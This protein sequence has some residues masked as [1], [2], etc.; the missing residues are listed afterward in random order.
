M[1]ASQMETLSPSVPLLPLARLLTE[2]LVVV[3][4]GARWGF[5]Q[6]WAGLGDRCVSV[7]FEPDRVECERLVTLH[8]GR[9]NLRFVPLALGARPGLATLYLTKNR[10]GCSVYPPSVTAMHRHPGLEGSLVEATTVIEMT[11]L[12]DWCASDGT[13][14]I[15][16]RYVVN[17][18][19]RSVRRR[20]HGPEAT[21]ARR[22]LDE[23]DSQSASMTRVRSAATERRSMQGS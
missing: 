5:S 2:P 12:D 8:Q 3:D 17:E 21:T 10:G 9:P 19:S 15:D 16:A 20:H 18:S 1:E 11:T 6:I 14:R 13:E 22:R 23:R 7:G 4:I